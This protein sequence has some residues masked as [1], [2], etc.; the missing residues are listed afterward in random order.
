L[1]RILL[2]YFLLFTSIGFSQSFDGELKIENITFPEGNQLPYAYD[3]TQDSSGMMWFRSGLNFYN[4]NGTELSEVTKEVMGFSP[5]RLERMPWNKNHSLFYMS[6]DSL[7]VYNPYTNEV[8]KETVG[9]LEAKFRRFQT[10]TSLISYI[11]VGKDEHVWGLVEPRSPSN[12]EDDSFIAR[13]VVRSDEHGKF[14]LIDSL[15]IS[16]YY[17]VTLVQDD[18]Y[19]VKCRDRIEVF[20]KN[21]RSKIYPFPDGPDPVMPSMVMDDDNTIWVV[22]SPDKLKDQYAVYFLKDGDDEFTRLEEEQ[23]PQ[24]KKRSEIFLTE[25]YLWHRSYPFSLSRMR[26]SNGSIEDFSEKVIKQNVNFPFYNSKLLNVF[27]DRSGDIWMTTRAGVVK[28]TIEDDIFLKFQQENEDFDCNTETCAIKA[29]TE[30]E[31]GNIYFAY[32]NGISKLDA[33]TGNLISLPLSIPPQKQVVHALTY[34]NGIIFWNEYAINLNANSVKKIFS[35]STYDYVSHALNSK[36]N[37]LWIGLNDWPFKLYCYDI[38]KGEAREINLPQGIFSNLNAEIRSMHYSPTTETL[39]LAVWMRGLLEIDGDGRLIKQHNKKSISDLETWHDDTMYDIYEDDKSQLWVGHGKDAGLSKLDLKT[40]E[41]TSYP[42]EVNNFT[43]ALKRVFHILPGEDEFLWLVTEK[44]TLRLNKSSGELIRFPM[45]P[46]LSKMAFHKLPGY[47]AKNETLYVGTQDGNLHAFKPKTLFEKAGFEKQYPIVIDRYERFNEKED[48][49]FTR[50]KNLIHLSEIELS[51]LDRYFS[52]HF[53]IPDFRITEQNLYSYWLEGYDSQWSSPARI[54]Q[55]R[56]ENLPPGKYTL[57]IRGGLT[58]DF[59]AS[60]E[61]KL[62][63]IV[64]QAWYKSWWAWCLYLFSFFGMVYL[65]YRYQIHRQLEK[66]EARRL[67]ELDALKSRL[68]TNITH[69]FRTPLTVIMGM[70]N[71]IDGHAEERKLIQRNSKNL[72]R[73]INQLLDLSKLDSGTLKMD[74]I[75]GDIVQYLQYLTESFYSMAD[76]KQI[77]LTFYPEIKELVMDYDETKIQHIVYN[78]LTNAIKFTKEEG[79]IILHIQQIEKNNTNWLQLKVSDTG[80]GISKENLPKIFDRFFQ[81]DGSS[82]RKEEGTGIG[83]ALTKELVEMMGGRIVAE[84]ELGKGSDFMVLLPIKKEKDT[85]KKE[86][87]DRDLDVNL[88]LAPKPSTKGLT[89]ALD[90]NIFSRNVETPSLLIIEDN[91]DVVT[92]RQEGIDKALA[93]IPDIII[94]DVMMPEKDGYEVCVILKNDQRTSHIPIILLTAKATIE[95]RVEGLK[96]GADAYLTKP[97]DKEELFIRLE[98]LIA[99]RRTLQERYSKTNLLTTD[100]GAKPKLSLDDLFLQ[101]LI[102]LVQPRID[103]SKLSV[104]DLC[105]SVNLSNTHLNRKLKALTGKTPSQFIRSIRLQKALELLQTT[106]QNISE[107]AYNVG[108]NDPNYFSRSFSEEFGFSPKS[109]RK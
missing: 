17:D 28:M 82:T 38:E 81:G 43:G 35:S 83:L 100:I 6:A 93:I 76:E 70:T 16:W 108:F 3:I 10:K 53:F 80:I 45:F 106:D 37:L 23:F 79:K 97:F 105:A 60:S 96:G 57:H 13:Y 103:D 2:Y 101:K 65:L 48:S 75:Q 19:Y 95:D 11:A 52:L 54:N 9:G 91:R 68:Y 33:I 64:H 88:N 47:R 20:N 67:K 73:L 18:Q 94:S 36:E 61:R 50:S 66:A 4:Y 34:T 44:G 77:R 41:V 26:I 84:S 8:I 56:Y 69:E 58:P 71:N 40:D 89:N 107:I 39:F 72:F 29:V 109:V 74:K 98:K 78:L 32:E 25:G 12:L 49:L 14:Q 92:Y 63:V 62:I 22:Y 59:Y 46:T 102:K 1:K 15:N 7:T 99:I 90:M 21:G 5:K 51:Y 31:L 27:E 87:S 55:L 104:S 30:D 42:Y 86:Q 85:N 24:S